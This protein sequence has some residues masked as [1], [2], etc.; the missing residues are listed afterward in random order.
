MTH[1]AEITAFYAGEKFSFV[2]KKATKKKAVDAA[3]KKYE[4]SAS[5]FEAEAKWLQ[6]DSLIIN[7]VVVDD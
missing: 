5:Y 1:T 2:A 3:F 4:A 6:F 7:G